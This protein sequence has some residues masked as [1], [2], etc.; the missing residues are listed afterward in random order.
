MKI[1]L[2]MIT[3]SLDSEAEIMT[4]V[5]NAEKY[6]HKL[7]CVI[8]AYARNIDP[9]V[10]NRLKRK[11]RLY[12][13]DIKNPRYCL[14]QFSRLGISSISTVTLLGCPVEIRR[15]MAPYG[16]NRN[17]VLFE[18]MMRGVDTLFF[19]DTDVIPSVLKMTPEGVKTE[20][21]D[22]F[23]AH[24][25]HLNTGAQVTTGEYSGYNILPHASF[26]GMD[27]L[28]AGVQKYDMLEYWKNSETHRCLTVQPS[29]RETKPCSKI[30]GGNCAIKLSAL[31]N[32]PPFFSSQYIVGG[33]MFLCRGED[34][35]LGLEIAKS[36]VTCTDI[37]LNPL[38]DT[39]KNYP[40]EPNLRDDQNTQDR[41]YY[42]CT[43]WVGRNPFLNF[44]RGA[45]LKATREYQYV[46]LARGLKA[47]KE[48]TANPRFLGV[49]KNFE[50]SWNSLGRYINEYERQLNAWE[51]LKYRYFQKIDV[52]ESSKETRRTHQPDAVVKTQ[53][54]TRHLRV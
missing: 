46:R 9:D 30:L 40:V 11:V 29:V 47:L 31:R 28:L 41:F 24:L 2:G 54:K 45:D 15:G 52:A 19:T 33:E 21:V 20:E 27:D 39:Y 17:I 42:A 44:I 25:E 3:K 7:D 38:H 43:G 48:Y 22:F 8:V 50:V 4:F 37:C 13:V 12:A 34:T 35:V 36:G 32:L 6:G 10:E 1:A 23:G 18:A 26:D 49:L 53:R 51:E 5:D 14:E 16:F